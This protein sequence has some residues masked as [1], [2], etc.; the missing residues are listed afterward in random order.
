VLARREGLFVHYRLA[1]PE[2]VSLVVALRH[3]AEQHLVVLDV[4]PE[5]VGPAVVGAIVHMMVGAMY[6][7]GF[8]FIV[9]LTK[10]SGVNRL[11]PE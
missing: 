2:V 4:R 10:L 1:E 8:A 9:R 3:T 11:S 6:G 5:Q 7:I